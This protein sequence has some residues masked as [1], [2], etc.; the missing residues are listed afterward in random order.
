MVKYF[1]LKEKKN[2]LYCIRFKDHVAISSVLSHA[3]SLRKSWVIPLYVRAV[4]FFSAIQH[5]E[6]PSLII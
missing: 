2:L 5:I 1:K 4:I 6:I 3:Y